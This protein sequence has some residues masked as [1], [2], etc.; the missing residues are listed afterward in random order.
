MPKN[1]A[2]S[3][4]EFAILV[5]CVVAAVVAIRF[6][7]ERGIQGK[8]RRTADDIGTAYFPGETTSTVNKKT[9]SRKTNMTIY[10]EPGTE[11][12]PPGS[13]QVVEG[14]H[15]YRRDDILEETIKEDVN[16]KVK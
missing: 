13:G 7:L 15:T 10:T 2:Q 8:I 16:E 5:A 3:T 1:K 9:L 12:L 11:E 4:L 6:Y 14:Q